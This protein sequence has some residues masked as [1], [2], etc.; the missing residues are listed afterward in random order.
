M[1]SQTTT[2]VERLQ[3]RRGE[4]LRQW[5]PLELDSIT[6]AR[7]NE[8][9]GWPVQPQA[10][11][12]VQPALLLQVG[13]EVVDVHH[14]RRPHETLDEGLRNPVNGGTAVWWSRPVVAGETVSGTVSIGSVSTR[15]G[16][17]GP[18]ALVVLETRITASDG[19]LVE[20]TDKTVVFRE[21]A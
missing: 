4:V 1:T 20:R 6:I 3:A 13:N 18:L 7:F 11:A 12:T 14:D 19:T 15:Q 17:S 16:K 8:A 9:E 5:G 21:G 10:K 2:P